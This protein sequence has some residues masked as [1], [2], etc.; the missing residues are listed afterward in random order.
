MAGKMAGNVG[1]TNGSFSFSFCHLDFQRS[2]QISNT[3]MFSTIASFFFFFNW[4]TRPR[5]RALVSSVIF[6]AG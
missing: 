4:R 2:Y 3:D 5:V 6:W 1:K